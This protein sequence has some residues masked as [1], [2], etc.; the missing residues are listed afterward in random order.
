MIGRFFPEGRNLNE[1]ENIA[2]CATLSG[3]RSAGEREVILEGK[4]LSCGADR[5]LTVSLGPFIGH[6]PRE[7]TALGIAEGTTREIAVLSRVG[8]PVCFTVIS[9]SGS[10]KSPE[11]I[12]SRRRA[13]EMAQ[14]HLMSDFKPGMVIPATVTHLEPFG[15]FVDIGCGLV[16][17]IG[18][19]QISVSRIPHP[20]CRF[21][22]GQEI[23]A[24]VVETDP[25]LN[26]VK[27]THRELLGTWEENARCFTPGMT[28][29]GHVRGIKEYG[30]FIELA[31]NL[32][33]LAEP[34]ADLKDGDRVSVFIKAILPDR[35]KI[36]LLI[37]DRLPPDPVPV[38]LHYFV[39]GGRLT[40]WLYAPECCRKA[41]PET[42]FSS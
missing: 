27:L 33:G 19:E 36:K 17:M 42:D 16:S 21:T 32:S 38:P 3:L 8:K 12:L 24:A 30:A 41:G 11:I 20:S 37:I 13:Q 29:A 14:H 34:R 31:P 2:A 7:E 25:G 10:E 1:A 5:E 23:F 26:R 28:V 4:A 15:A 9:V 35:M 40:R 6:I 18:I 22:P 39:S